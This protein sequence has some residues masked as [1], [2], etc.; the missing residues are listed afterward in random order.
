MSH[1][2]AGALERPWIWRISAA[3]R[4]K[5]VTLRNLTL[6]L[7][8]V[9]VGL[10]AAGNAVSLFYSWTTNAELDYGEGF[11]LLA[12]MRMAQGINPYSL[13]DVPYGAYSTVYPPLFSLLAAGLI[14]LFGAHVLTVRILAIVGT[15]LG[16]CALYYLASQHIGRRKALLAPLVWLAFLDSSQVASFAKPDMLAAGVAAVGLC[17]ARKNLWVAAALCV[18][19]L[20]TKPSTVAV[21]VAIVVWLLLDKKLLRAGLFCL[22][23]GSALAA[24][25]GAAVYVFGPQYLW[26]VYGIHSTEGTYL[27]LLENLSILYISLE[28]LLVYI[29]LRSLLPLIRNPATRLE[30]LYAAAGLLTAASLLKEGS[31]PVYLAEALLSAAL[32]VAIA[33]PY[34]TISRRWEQ[35]SLMLL[36]A[37][38]VY[39]AVLV[40]PW[41][42][43][44][45]LPQAAQ[46]LEGEVLPYM[47]S[48]DGPVLSDDASWLIDAGRPNDTVE[49][50]LISSAERA[51]P[52]AH[53]QLR[54][55]LEARRFSL[56]VLHDTPGVES[57]ALHLHP[58]RFSPDLRDAIATNYT[59]LT[60][61]QCGTSASP[62]LRNLLVPRQ[63]ASE[64]V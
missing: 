15:L 27:T 2:R 12:G 34:A 21:P 10:F 17:F 44:A 52:A 35:C 56:L 61:V 38:L 63:S 60:T 30:G 8:L 54:A 42:S 23:V 20:W 31:S 28:A 6:A 4:S 3:L 25:T 37:F 33:W 22:A 24:L 53:E 39:G 49:L 5:P 9:G 55:D 1:A 62:T 50:F 32:V 36:S 41:S 18:V 40:H 43:A 46:C 26:L 64:D 7:L 58:Q 57:D 19:A 29:V 47:A 45:D 16:M 11:M 59:R 13:G 51:W 14:D 48:T